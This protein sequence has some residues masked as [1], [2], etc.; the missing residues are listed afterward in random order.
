MQAQLDAQVA[1]SDHEPAREREDLVD[2]AQRRR[3]LDLGDDRGP[4]VLRHA[5]G[6]HDVDELLDV[7]PL[8]RE[9]ERNVVDALREQVLGVLSVLDRQRGARD[10]QLGHVDPLAALEAAAQDDLARHR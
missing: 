7:L 8:L 6:V 1:A 4:R 5:L 2:V 3:L 10:L 9:R